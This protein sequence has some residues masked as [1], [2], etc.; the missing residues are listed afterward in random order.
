M[1]LLDSSNA[2]M[3]LTWDGL[4]HHYVIKNTIDAS[5][6][7]TSGGVGTLATTDTHKLLLIK[8]G[9]LVNRVWIRLVQKGTVGATTISKL[10]DS[11][12]DDIWSV[13]G[14]IKDMAIGTGGTV[15]KVAGGSANG[16]LYDADDYI[17]MTLATAN[18]DGIIEVAA[19]IIDVFGQESISI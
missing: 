7:V 15:G 10:G 11:G 5:K 14:G 4:N 19:E 1:A 9:W 13:V 2:T 3:A 18:F 8:E 16:L 17:V 6:A 12:T